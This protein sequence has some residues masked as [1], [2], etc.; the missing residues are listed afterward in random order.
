MRLEV[1]SDT[2][3]PWCLIGKRRLETALANRQDLD[4]EVVWRPFELN[5]DMPPEGVARED[6]LEAKF[7]GPERADEIYAAIRAAGESEDIP[8]DFERIGRVPN[9]MDSHRLID[10]AG[11]E[12]RQDAV[13]EGLF[14]A[15][16]IEGRDVGDPEVLGEVAAAAGMDGERCAAKL[17]GDE[18]RERIRSECGEARRLGI[19][20]VPF[21]IFEQKYAVSGAQAPEVF[22]QAF[23]TV[24]KEAAPALA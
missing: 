15:Y 3:C 13:V 6:Y 21:F 10:W 23:D 2:V 24:A 11:A 14:S 4:V 20:G 19:H 9:T 12:G 8:F 1:V 7:G 18:D 16:F 22:L 5:P 17:D